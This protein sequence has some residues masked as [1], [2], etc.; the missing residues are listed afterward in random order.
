MAFRSILIFSCRQ[1]RNVSSQTPVP[2]H[3]EHER[4]ESLVAPLEEEMMALT[5][6]GKNRSW[7]EF[8]KGL[9]YGFVLEFEN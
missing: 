4:W 1:N 6:T 9:A 3:E 8:N 2:V 5:L 7:E